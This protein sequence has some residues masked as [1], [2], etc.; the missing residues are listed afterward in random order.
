MELQKIQHILP[1]LHMTDGSE[2]LMFP[3]LSRI[4]KKST[5]GNGSICSS[6][7]DTGMIVIAEGFTHGSGR[8]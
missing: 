4:G 1:G 8:T 3:G 5:K 7:Q 2:Q 6:A